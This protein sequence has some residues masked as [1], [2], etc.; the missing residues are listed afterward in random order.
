MKT[1]IAYYGGKQRLVPEILPLIPN[2]I[3]SYVECFVGGGAVFFAKNPHRNEVINDFDGRITNFYQQV[4]TNFHELQKLIQAS[5]HSEILHTESNTVLNDPNE[6]PVRRAWA[7]WFQCTCSFSHILGGGFAFGENGS[8]LNTANKR[9][10]FTE[11]YMHRLRN[12]EV[13]NRDAL[14]IIK[15]KGQGESTLIFADPPYFNS[16]MAHYDGYTESDFANLL[17]ALANCKAKFILT[18]Y[19]SDLLT[20]FREEYGWGSKDLKQIVSVTGKR[21]E[22]KY[23][24]EC[25]TYNFIPPNNQPSLFGSDVVMDLEEPEEEN[26]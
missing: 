17:N 15:L 8:G 1:P 12:C 25:I 7:F 20:K 16:N 6:T 2:G 22:T 14:D 26:D 21:E 13:F 24:T 9:D 19:P 3:V 18:S 4:K 10:N 11:R 23:K 5:L